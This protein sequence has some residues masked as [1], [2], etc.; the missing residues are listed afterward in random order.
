MGFTYGQVL[1]TQLSLCALPS[2]LQSQLLPALIASAQSNK[3]LCVL[4]EPTLSFS[5]RFM[6]LARPT[7][8]AAY[9]R[10]DFISFALD[11]GHAIRRSVIGGNEDVSVRW[12]VGM[13]TWA[14]GDWWEFS[15]LVYWQCS[16]LMRGSV[17]WDVHLHGC[18]SSFRRSE[19]LSTN[20]AATPCLYRC[21]NLK[22]RY[23]IKL[24]LWCKLCKCLFD[25]VV[26]TACRIYL[27]LR[28]HCSGLLHSQ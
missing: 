6:T 4:L 8:S 3:G 26:Q 14:F 2:P 20:Y 27:F 16:N 10:T 23:L 11:C 18:I 17:F 28:I 24:T 13:K 12:L 15:L 25:V 21:E 19:T 7:N 9:T 22:I 1:C 5:I